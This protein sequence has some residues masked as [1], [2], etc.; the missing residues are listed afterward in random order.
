MIAE[1]RKPEGGILETTVRATFWRQEKVEQEG[2]TRAME[3]RGQASWPRTRVLWHPYTQEST[4][5]CA[6]VLMCTRGPAYAQAGR[7]KEIQGVRH[8]FVSTL[9]QGRHS[10]F[11]PSCL[12]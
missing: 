9:F 4:P 3:G 5:V 2:G 12:P 10:C 11:S 7:N 8:K 1:I 6:D